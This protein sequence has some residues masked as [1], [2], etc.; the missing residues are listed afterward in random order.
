M[1]SDKVASILQEIK[2]PFPIS[3]KEEGRKKKGP[4]PFTDKGPF[5]IQLCP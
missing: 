3:I 1:E 4:L 2:A 5:F